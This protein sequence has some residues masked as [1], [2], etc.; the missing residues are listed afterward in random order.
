MTSIRSDDF[1]RHMGVYGICVRKNQL[2]VIEKTLGPYTG[3]YDLPG[4]RPE[5]YESLTQTI[6]REFYEETGFVV[7]NTKQLGVCDFNVL[8]T[9]KDNTA[10]Q[11]HHIA[12]MYEV[13]VDTEQ[14]PRSIK[15]FVGQDSKAAK[16]FPVTDLT[17]SNS[18]PL[19]MN[20]VKW[21]I[22]RIFPV[23]DGFFDY[24]E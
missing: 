22:S 17:S 5:N 11:L 4:G 8:W 7:S 23:N 1:H 6:V 16:W 2:L 21:F 9:L 3:Q 13:E 19:V 12:I 14:D 20:A 15:T 18:S 10:E 24:R